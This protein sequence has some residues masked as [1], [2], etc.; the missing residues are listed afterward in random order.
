MPTKSH[1]FIAIL[2]VIAAGLLAFRKR[3]HYTAPETING[4]WVPADR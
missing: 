3:S 4:T 2:L 1:R